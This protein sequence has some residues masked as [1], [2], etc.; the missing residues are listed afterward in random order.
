MGH[1]SKS[2]RYTEPKQLCRECSDR[3]EDHSGTCAR[4]LVELIWS[5]GET[6]ECQVGIRR[7]RPYV[8]HAWLE[9]GHWIRAWE[10]LPG[11]DWHV[12]LFRV[13]QILRPHVKARYSGFRWS[14][15][16]QVL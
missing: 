2:I 6:R 16:T 9:D 15:L 10:V 11:Y 12:V 4:G 7:D 13:A 5:D 8:V 1:Q 3:W 14:G